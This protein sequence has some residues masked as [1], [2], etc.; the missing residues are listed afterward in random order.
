MNLFFYTNITFI[1]FNC[2]DKIKIVSDAYNL[3]IFM[4]PYLNAEPIT[5]ET[6]KKHGVIIYKLLKKMKEPFFNKSNLKIYYPRHKNVFPIYTAN[7]L[8]F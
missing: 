6:Q 2:K 7:F 1:Y 5:R 8:N 4:I 3:I